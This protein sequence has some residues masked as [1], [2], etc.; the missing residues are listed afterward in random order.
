M[1]VTVEFIERELLMKFE[2]SK[3]FFNL[4]A[5]I[6]IAMLFTGCTSSYRTISADDAM[7]IMSDTKDFILLDVRT[8]EEYDKRHIPGAILL[9]IDEIK[10]GNVSVLP[11][12]KQKILVYCWTGRRSEDSAIM[13]ADM[14]YSN[15]LNMGGIVDWKGA[16]EGSEVDN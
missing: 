8:K 5:G 11:D 12:K 13:L 10:K 4:F 16:V 1:I 7:K 15:V 2:R 9:P 14:G 3:I 6:I